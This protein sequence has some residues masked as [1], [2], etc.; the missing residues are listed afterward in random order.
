M[1]HII[2]SA[3]RFLVIAA[4]SAQASAAVINVDFQPITGNGVTFSGVGA[5]PDSGT[6]WNGISVPHDNSFGGTGGFISGAIT[7]APLVDSLGNS[8]PITLT[9]DV[10]GGTFAAGGNNSIFVADQYDLLRDQLLVFNDNV[11][12]ITLANVPVG[13]YDFYLYGVGDNFG[14]PDSGSNR[15]TIFTVTGLTLGTGSTTGSQP[16]NGLTLGEEYTL[17]QGIAPA[18]NGTISIA[19]QRNGTAGEG[20]FN[21]FQ[22]VAVPEP[23][24]AISACLGAATLLGFRRRRS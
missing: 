24:A 11:H 17:I 12:T 16:T 2:P 15:S 23:S 10:G 4:A 1:L 18:V 22:M 8:S 20:A 21:G 7:A 14:A 9:T 19:Y 5:A 6:S 3:L 13:L